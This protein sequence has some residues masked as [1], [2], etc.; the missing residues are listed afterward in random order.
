[1]WSLQWEVTHENGLAF[2]FAGFAV[3]K[4]SVH[5]KWS[6]VGVILFLALEH[7]VT[8]FFKVWVGECEAHCLSKILDWGN[9]LEDFVKTGNVRYGVSSVCFVFGDA[10]LPAFRTDQP[11][12]AVGLY[13]E[14]VW[15]INRLTNG[16]KIH[17]I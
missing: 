4:L 6:G 13:A 12:K 3:F 10:L 9:L 16:A 1:M 11:I 7:G 14:E 5:V 17:T 2:N 15:H 8:W